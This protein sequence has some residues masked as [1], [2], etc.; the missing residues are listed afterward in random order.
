MSVRATRIGK[1]ET[2]KLPALDSSSFP[3]RL[4]QVAGSH[5]CPLDGSGSRLLVRFVVVV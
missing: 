5:I 3:R 2:L 1:T 4:M